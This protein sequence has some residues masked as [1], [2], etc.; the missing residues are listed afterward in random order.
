MDAAQGSRGQR[1][2]CNRSCPMIFRLSAGAMASGLSMD[3]WRYISDFVQSS[4]LS[5]VCHKLR[6]FLRRRHISLHTTAATVARKAARLKGDAAIR[7]LTVYSREMQDDAVQALASLKDLPAL[8]A[9][10]LDLDHTHMGDCAAEALSALK[11][12]PSLK[13]LT[14]SLADTHIG[15]SGAQALAE[16]N[17]APSLKRLTL[18]LRSTRVGVCTAFSSPLRGHTPVTTH[19]GGGGVSGGQNFT[20]KFSLFREVAKPPPP[21][22]FAACDQQLHCEFRCRWIRSPLGTDSNP[23]KPI[24][25]QREPSRAHQEV[26]GTMRSPPG[27]A[28]SFRIPGGGEVFPFRNNPRRNCPLATPTG[29]QNPTAQPSS[30]SI[31]SVP[32]YSP[33]HSP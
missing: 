22:L 29:S 23:P 32:T 12:A 1:Y 19:T 7:T 4:L 27:I 11:H 21:A 13:V 28:A 14:L 8:M 30:S 2:L 5:C 20:G 17:D 6:F 9:L 26:S 33:D 10:R 15:D 25:K 31:T 16:L 18:N 24:R 3:E